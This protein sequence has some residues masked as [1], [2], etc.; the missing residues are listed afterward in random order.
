M[1]REVDIQG[2]DGI[3]EPISDPSLLNDLFTVIIKCME[4]STKIN[5]Q[6]NGQNLSHASLVSRNWN[7]FL[8][9][10]LDSRRSMMV[11]SACYTSNSSYDS[12]S[13]E[14]LGVYNNWEDALMATFK[15]C[16]SMRKVIE[17]K[18]FVLPTNSKDFEKL[19][20]DELDPYRSYCGESRIG[21]NVDWGLCE[22]YGDKEIYYVLANELSK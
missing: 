19:I 3:Q 4:N 18:D 13:L 11:Y 17:R 20:G 9:P 2:A 15:H 12:S 7:K 1:K 6:E 22:R 16:S 8:Q 10:L 14:M 21:W 5:A